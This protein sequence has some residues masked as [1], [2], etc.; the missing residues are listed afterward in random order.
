VVSARAFFV[1][2]ALAFATAQLLTAALHET[3][4]GLVAQALGFAPKIYAFYED[5]PTG[6][7]VQS[8]AILA[9]GPLGSLVLGGLFR[10]W[11][12]R[13][14]ATYGFWRLLLFWLAWL[15]IMEFVNYLFVTPWL[16][17]G[18]TAKLADIFGAPLWS[19]Y[20]VAVLGAGLVFLLA[21]F[22]A[23]DMFAVAPAGTPLDEPGA[24]RKYIVRSFYLP[25]LVGVVLTGLGGIGGRPEFVFFGLLGTLGNIDLVAASLY[26]RWPIV[27]PPLAEPAATAQPRIEPAGIALYV[28]VVLF[29]ILVLSHGMP[30]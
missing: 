2:S 29:Y 1:N 9:A 16:T 4:H 26:V 6:T 15:G 24:R 30:V 28:A 25:L 10:L 19:R 27:T 18:D 8:A 13:G 21:P 14:K 5:N 12:S 3:C 17:L 23:A 22:A 20:A 7:P 11:Y